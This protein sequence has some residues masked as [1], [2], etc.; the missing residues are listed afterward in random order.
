ML[1]RPICFIVVIIVVG[2]ICIIIY[3]DNNDFDIYT[4]KYSSFSFAVY[5]IEG[6][7]EMTIRIMD[8][9]LSDALFY[10][11]EELNSQNTSYIKIHLPSQF[12]ISKNNVVL[13][14]GNVQHQ[15]IPQYRDQYGLSHKNIDFYVF[16]K[17]ECFPNI[18]ELRNGDKI[19]VYKKS[20]KLY[21]TKM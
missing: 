17:N 18:I 19:I 11:E 5:D 15:L 10:Q 16:G 14:D 2:F 6:E 3:D 1:K 20:R 21:I 12:L 4:H 13:Y 7:N 8:Y 9:T